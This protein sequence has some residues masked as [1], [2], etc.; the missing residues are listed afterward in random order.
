M[1]ARAPLELACQ[2]LS[3]CL[4]ALLSFVLLLSGFVQQAEAQVSVNSIE[5]HQ[6]TSGTAFCG[7][8]TVAEAQVILRG[9]TNLPGDALDWTIRRF[10]ITRNAG[11]FDI[12]LANTGADLAMPLPVIITT[13]G[14]SVLNSGDVIEV[15]AFWNGDPTVESP[16]LFFNCSAVGAVRAGGRLSDALSND[17]NTNSLPDAGDEIELR[18]EIYDSGGATLSNAT[19]QIALDPDVT[20]IASSIRTTPIARDDAFDAIGHVRLAVPA[21]GVLANDNDPDGR[22]GLQA[23]IL[24][25]SASLKGGSVNV[26]A[27]GSFSY[28]SPLGYRGADSFVYTIVDSEGNRDQATVSIQVADLVW[29]VDNTAPGGGDG[30]ES[31][32]FNSVAAFNLVQG[33]GASAPGAGDVI[34]VHEGSGSYSGGISLLNGQQLIGQGVDLVVQGQTITTASTQ[35]LLNNGS[36][37][38]L[39]LAQDNV[40]R[41]LN[42]SATGGAGISGTS[43]GVCTINSVGVSATGHPALNLQS[44]SLNATFGSVSSANS[45][46]TGLN[47]INLGGSM[48][49][50]GG[51]ISAAAGTAVNIDQGDGAIDYGGDITN[52]AGRVLSISNRS[53]GS[54]VLGGT[55]NDDDPDGSLNSGILL[56]NNNSG[57]PLIRFSGEVNIVN[58]SGT[59]L[60]LSGNSGA[61]IDV[62]DCDITNTG[63]NQKG[64]VASGG[65]TLQSST[66][67]LNTGSATALDLNGMTLGMTLRSVSV[68]GASEGIVFNNTGGSFEVT[69]TGS[70]DGSGGTIQNISNSGISLTQVTNTTFRNMDLNNANTSGGCGLEVYDENG[71]INCKAAVNLNN[72]DGVRLENVDITGTTEHGLNGY[73]VTHLEI[74]NCEF[75][76]CGSTAFDAGIVITDLFGTEEDNNVNVFNKLTVDNSANFN[77][78]IRNLLRTNAFSGQPDRLELD[79]C[80]IANSSRVANAD[81]MTVSLRDDPSNNGAH[82]QTI[83]THCTFRDNAT[84]NIQ[85]DAGINARS[86][87]LISHSDFH[88]SNTAINISGSQNSQTSFL[89]TTNAQISSNA[90]SGINLAIN[91]NAQFTGSILDNSDVN[92]AINN[93]PSFG[94]AMVVDA[95]GSATARIEGN[96]FEDFMIGIYASARNAGAGATHVTITGNTVTTGGLNAWNAIWIEGGNSSP[97]EN[98]TV[99]A[100]LSDNTLTTGSGDE[101]IY[102]NQYPGNVVQL[103]G[104]SG[105]GTDPAVVEAFLDSTADGPNGD[106]LVETNFGAIVDYTSATCSEP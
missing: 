46:T 11:P 60:T 91:S 80:T 57:N 58:S 44:G 28:E 19:V 77:I 68:N 32:P 51:Q 102:I 66:G 88:N 3:Q 71:N 43:F 63:T 64:I 85:I 23:A 103:Q 78:F 59:A 76:N 34:F 54:V 89:I 38:G 65:G 31:S 86:D 106:A 16:H 17:V 47:L 94:V 74:D 41:G 9:S 96:T 75:R 37:A 26:N 2:A 29:F 24:S 40:I 62:G 72:V 83:V 82:F 79:S 12:V 99:C 33:G 84:D 20:L 18:A 13:G 98:N 25:G 101:G 39:N 6:V 87:V 52:D 21:P 4:P 15:F 105:D 42:I 45:G 7:G 73:R 67:S 5:F 1:N 10:N 27:D 50:A 49:V 95:T 36:G 100:H 56:Q 93:N 48:A 104:F 61:T 30:R 81:G 22:P 69:G 70:T 55:L 92:S 35:P 14:I 90:G 97:G 8:G 53:G